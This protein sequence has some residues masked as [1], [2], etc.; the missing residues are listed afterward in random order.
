MSEKRVCLNANQVSSS[1]IHKA[2]CIL[3]ASASSCINKVFKQLPFN[4]I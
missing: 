3:I 4:V 1:S 2:D